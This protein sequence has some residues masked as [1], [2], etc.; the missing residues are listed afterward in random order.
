LLLEPGE[1]SEKL[2]LKLVPEERLVESSNLKTAVW[3]EDGDG[4][5][6]PLELTSGTGGVSHGVIDIMQFSGSR[7]LYVKASGKTKKGEPLEYLDSP[8]E[9][10]GIKPLPEP[11]EEPEPVSEPEPEPEPETEEPPEEGGMTWG[12]IFGLVNLLLI[13]GAGALFWW[14]RRSRQKNRVTLV[15]EIESDQEKRPEATE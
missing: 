12:I 6:Y 4:V 13:A 5:Q 8:A 3:L 7:R 15:D 11:V 1:T 10:E 2:S 14:M 9:V